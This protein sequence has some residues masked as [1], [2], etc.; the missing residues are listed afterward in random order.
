MQKRHNS[1]AD[2]REN[3]AQPTKTE[4]DMPNTHAIG[5]GTLPGAM[6]SIVKPVSSR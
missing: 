1:A 2:Q 6:A 5:F 3:T 4:H